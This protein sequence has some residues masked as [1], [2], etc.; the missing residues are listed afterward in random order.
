MRFKDKQGVTM[1]SQGLQ[2]VT[3]DYKVLQGV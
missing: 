3:I 2:G 1:G